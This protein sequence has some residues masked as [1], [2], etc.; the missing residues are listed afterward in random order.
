M[1]VILSLECSMDIHVDVDIDIRVGSG[2]AFQKGIYKN[3]PT[4]VTR[5]KQG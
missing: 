2:D 4:L 5:A 3:L 1:G